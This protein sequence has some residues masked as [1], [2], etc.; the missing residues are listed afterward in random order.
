MGKLKLVI[1]LF[2]RYININIPEIR[3]NIQMNREN[4]V[5]DGPQRDGRVILSCKN[6]TNFLYQESALHGRIVLSLK[7]LL[8]I[9]PHIRFRICS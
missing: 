6:S 9:G 1:N 8:C 7:G 5:L 3:L 4:V 2:Y